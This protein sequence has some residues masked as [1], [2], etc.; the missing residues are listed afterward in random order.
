LQTQFPTTNAFGAQLKQVAQMMQV[1]AAL[2]VKRQI[3]FVGAGNFDTHGAQL[4]LQAKLLSQLSPALS[5]FYN[6]TVELGLASQATTFTCSDFSRAFQPNSAAG[7]DHAWGGHHIIM[8]GAVQG[9]KMY[10]KFPTLALGGPDDSDKNGRWI[11]TTSS[12][13]YAATLAQWFGVSTA[14]LPYVLPSLGNFS[15][16]TLGFLG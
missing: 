12:S 6:A 11:P 1:H 2:G 13:Q 14:D 16:A 5:A 9:G 8:G 4:Q 3:F 15:Q 10:G 7:S